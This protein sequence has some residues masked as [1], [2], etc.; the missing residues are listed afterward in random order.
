MGLADIPRTLALLEQERLD[1]LLVTGPENFEYFAG[2]S[3]HPLSMWRRI[4]PVSAV[5]NRDGL[6]S[7]IASDAQEGAVSRANPDTDVLS[8]PAWIE[9]LGVEEDQNL[10]AEDLIGRATSGR[11]NL[12]PETYD[13]ALVYSLVK[14]ALQNAGLIGKRVGVEFESAPHL[15]VLRLNEL[16]PDTEFVNSSPLIRELRVIK[17]KAEIDLLRVASELAEIGIVASLHGADGSTSALDVRTR[18]GEAVSAEARARK[19][20]GFRSS[21]TTVHLGPHLWGTGD[22][23]RTLQPGDLIQFD[24]GAQVG[25]YNSDIGRTFVYQKP[26]QQQQRIQEALLAGYRA[27][28]NEL[29]P[30]RRYCDVFNVTQ[31]TVR[32]AGFPSY[33]R[34]HFG[35]SIG[36]E[37]F[38]E[39]WPWISATE[40]R[41]LEP[42]MVVAFE[43]PYYIN[44]IGGFQN[45]DNILITENGHVS[46]NSTP[47]DLK[48][49]GT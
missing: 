18:Y 32:A 30:G 9:R 36:S 28:V 42:G 6:H 7:L 12:R 17:T 39:E 16:V 46:F 11:E 31:E 24:S 5:I 22:P 40:T 44:G 38:G 14:E 21:R 8:Y 10:S 4:G 2:A 35:H 48:V 25:G 41:V 20:H 3:S 43:V 47:M 37:I 13:E 45:E 49:I 15:D 1:G 34:G 26:T 33:S 23:A 27:G 29:K 19:L